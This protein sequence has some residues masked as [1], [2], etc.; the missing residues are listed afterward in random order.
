LLCQT[1]YQ[2]AI[3]SNKTLHKMILRLLPVILVA[4]ATSVS[5]NTGTAKLGTALEMGGVDKLHRRG[6]KGKGIKKGIIGTGDDYHHPALG[7]S[8]GP[9]HNFAGGYSLPT[10]VVH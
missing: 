4:T 5:G 1:P 8:F 6:I 2:S 3:P 9:G 10:T 7:A